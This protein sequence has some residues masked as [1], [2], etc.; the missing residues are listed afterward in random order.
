[1][2]AFL[3]QKT[4]STHHKRQQAAMQRHQRQSLLALLG[5]ALLL[6]VVDAFVP[7]ARPA[8]TIQ[9]QQRRGASP[10][11]A[12]AAQRPE[13]GQEAAEGRRASVEGSVGFWL[14]RAWTLVAPL[15][16][17]V[18]LPL[19]GAPTRWV[20]RLDGVGFETLVDLSIN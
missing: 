8:A 14:H 6:A 13:P 16:V 19:A 18:A 17:M 5:L 9:R 15:G 1:M 4:H 7:A 10:V 2:R 11:A 12:A 3:F 20:L